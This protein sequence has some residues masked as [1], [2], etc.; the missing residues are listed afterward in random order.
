[1]K[2]GDEWLGPALAAAGSIKALKSAG[3]SAAESGGQGALEALLLVCR[4]G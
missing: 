3:K 1:M 4:P 2:A